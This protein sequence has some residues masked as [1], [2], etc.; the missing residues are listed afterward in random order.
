VERGARLLEG[1]LHRAGP[2]HT[3]GGDKGCGDARADD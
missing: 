3:I 2:L 1:E